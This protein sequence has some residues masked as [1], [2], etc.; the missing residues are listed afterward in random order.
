MQNQSINAPDWSRPWLA[1]PVSRALMLAAALLLSWP[2]I[3]SAATP[4]EYNRDIRPILAE[5]CFACHGLDGSS[6]EADLRLDARELA[7][8]AGA[9]Q[10]GDPEASELIARVMSDDADMVMP[11]PAS[12]KSLSSEE[13]E[14]LRRWVAEGAEYQDHWALIP[15]TKVPPPQIDADR[16]DANWCK[17]EI[18]QFVLARLHDSGLRPAAEES[19]RRFFRRL[20]FDITGLPPSVDDVESF[21][22]DYAA[23]GDEA[24]SQW[25]DRLMTSTAWGEHRAR[26]W[27]D[28]AR[29]ADTHGMH[30]D[31]YR[32]MWPYRDWVIRSFNQNQPFDDFTLEQLAGDLLPDP[33]LDQLIAT[34]FQRCAMTTNEGGTIDEENVAMYAADRVQT[35]GWVYLGLTTNCCQCHDH[36]FDPITIKDY[37]AL[38]AFFRNTTQ[39]PKDGNSK[40]GRS[41]VAFVPIQQ[42]LARW[43]EL[44]PEIKN[45]EQA[46]DLHVKNSNPAFTAWLDTVS[47]ESMRQNS[48]TIKRLIHLPLNEKKGRGV[49]VSEDA[50]WTADGKLGDTFKITA[51]TTL[52]LGG[53]GDFEKDEP[54]SFAAW[55]RLPDVNKAASIIARMDSSNAS[56]GWDVFVA[57]GSVAMHLV[58]DWPENGLKVMTDKRVLNNNQWHHVCVSWDGSG[59]ASGVRIFV[60]GKKQGTRTEKETLGK[61]ATIRTATPLRVGQRS[62]G[63]LLEGGSIQDLQ[64]FTRVL[65][66]D[67]VVR[68]QQYS[69]LAKALDVPVGQRN[70]ADQDALRQYFLENHD[71]E[72]KQRVAS[73]RKL[74][75]EQE[76]IRQRGAITHIQEER[77]NTPAMANILMRG[78]Y[79]NVGESVAAAPPAVLHA[80]PSEAP[81]NRLGLAQWV[82]DPAN[83]LT[84]RVTVNRFWQEIFGQGIV[85]TPEDFGVMGA[86]P[87]HPGLIDWLAVDFVENGW[88]VKRFFKQMLM[89]ATYRQAAITTAEKLEKDRDNLLLS[90]GPRFR[91]DAEM[92]RDAALANSGLMSQKMYGPGTRPYQ[93][94]H[95]WDIV[96]LPEGNTRIYTTDSGEDLYRRSI[97][98][99]W[100]RMAPPPG[101]EAFNAPNREVCTVRRERTNTPLQALVTLNDPQF[102]EAAKKLAEVAL[103][104]ATDDDRALL[105]FIAERVLARTLRE[106]E[107]TILSTILAD[108]RNHYQAHPQDASDLLAVGDSTVDTSL[109]ASELAAWT[110]TCNQIMNLDEALTK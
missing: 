31:N 30:F 68:V 99:F 70:E 72:Y 61:D 62:S 39:P 71:P 76:A 2:S 47:A 51:T 52:E 28:A 55:I 94:D 19:P 29:Y 7:I 16:P 104:T 75:R 17:N 45:A 48:P 26:F 15:P 11:P 90:R 77:P 13:R 58:Q 12:K 9:I 109:D 10:P 33:T 79:D 54:F 101:L 93:P 59:N 36:K 22:A 88:D 34:G 81:A 44:E 57:G 24:V 102:V 42:D 4:L 73:I 6:R 107:I 60:D 97:Y 98:S 63:S 56:R 69:V 87:T 85:V 74:Q 95:L 49:A 38:A 1:A 25:I 37:Y 83:P 32:E 67:E 3:A 18:D 40:D 96:G 84:S 50:Q 20:S 100:K 41:K 91:M 89:S 43:N 106:P 35:F 108:L 14:T 82:L 46:R 78:E 27:L 5:Y 110:M 105:D 103:K 23:S 21:V 80:M 66:S 92:I 65:E 8:D 64:L 53:L 86:P